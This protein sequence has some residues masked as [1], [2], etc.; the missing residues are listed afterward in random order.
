MTATEAG[1]V[2]DWS[3]A[4]VAERV[5][6]APGEFREEL[7]LSTKLGAAAATAALGIGT[8]LAWTMR[9][10]R[11]FPWCRLGILAFLLALPG[12]LLG[13]GLIRLLNQPADS[14]LAF[15]AVL[16]DSNFAPWLAQTLRALPLVTLMLWPALA[17]VPQSM[18]DAAATETEACQNVFG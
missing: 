3:A 13:I 5:A 8:L 7:R 16:Y 10:A 6:V 9:G 12:P 2:R 17:S 14:P 18:L 1:R 4:K 15:L 11:R